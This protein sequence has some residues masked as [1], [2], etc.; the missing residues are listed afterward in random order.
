M[1][2]LAREFASIPDPYTGRSLYGGGNKSFHTV[3]EVRE[4][5]QK[6]RENHSKSSKP[7][8]SNLPPN[9]K[10]QEKMLFE[11]ADKY[12]KNKTEVSINQ[13]IDDEEE[14][15]LIVAVQ[16]ITNETYLP[17]PIG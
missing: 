2:E 15:N 3:D 7:K 4:A 10:E 9:Y 13:P 17:I 12:R 14:S 16:P 6:A 8:M 1:M 11:G 5:L